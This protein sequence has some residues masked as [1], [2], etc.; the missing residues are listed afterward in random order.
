MPDEV[1]TLRTK[2]ERGDA[3][4]QFALGMRYFEGDGVPQSDSEATKWIRRA[5][6]QGHPSAS[7]LL[8]AMTRGTTVVEV[9][10]VERSQPVAPA[11]SRPPASYP[12]GN[13]NG[14]GVLSNACPSCNGSGL[15]GPANMRS[16]CMACNGKG[17][18]KCI[19][20]NGTGKR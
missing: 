16:M 7:N 15:S 6:T 4:A 8:N 19:P 5:A 12:C 14:R 13:C 3:D 17:F 20:C 18:P 9:P 11:V 2:A 10:V 1:K